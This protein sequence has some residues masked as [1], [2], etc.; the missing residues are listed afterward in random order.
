V[1]KKRLDLED[2]QAAQ[3]RA[4]RWTKRT[5]GPICRRRPAT[6][7]GR[8]PGYPT[9]WP[10]AGPTVSGHDTKRSRAGGRPRPDDDRE[11]WVGHTATRCTKPS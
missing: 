9:M 7:S 6:V 1:D 11:G 4:A 8:G 3:R 5:S 2:E 10:S